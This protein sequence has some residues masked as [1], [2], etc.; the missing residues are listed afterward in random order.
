MIFIEH[1]KI[2]LFELASSPNISMVLRV[3]KI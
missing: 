2:I 3:V 1:S